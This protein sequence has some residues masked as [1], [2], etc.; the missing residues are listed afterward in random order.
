MHNPL[1]SKQLANFCEIANV[2]SIRKAA[3]NLNLTTSAVSHS[4]KRL[5]ED[6]GCK[7]F[8]R[9]TRSI[10]LTYAG[11]RLKSLAN[12]LMG[13]LT[14]ARNLVSEWGEVH[15]K[16]L[17]IGASPV[18]CQHILP[19]ALRELKESFP[20]MNIQILIGTS[21]QLAE[22]IEDNK[23]D[24]AIYPANED[25]N[26]RH[27]I[28]IGTDTLEFIV[29]PLHPWAQ[30]G[31][32]DISGIEAQRVIVTESKS[33]TFDLIS[34]YFR[35][36]QKSLTPFIEISNEE[37]IKRLVELDIGIGILPNWAIKNEIANGTL[38]RFPLGRRKLTR[39]WIIAHKE[40]R[41]L[42]FA[43]SLLVGVTQTV[44]QT[45]FSN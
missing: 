6:L 26:K 37:V 41:E 23:V 1:D 11:Q 27:K 21:Y 31:Q 17:R 24:L 25:S 20:G 42:S 29:N 9:D 35:S 45:V 14:Q 28:L 2:H 36:Y 12:E 10:T 34:T 18:A 15:Q 16:T 44:A 13:S 33:Y 8:D 38:V 30:G 19:M 5:E 22:Y 7:L 43:E 3:K 40:S 32:A 39:R 4:L